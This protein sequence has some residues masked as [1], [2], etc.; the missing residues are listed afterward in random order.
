MRA[1][2]VSDESSASLRR[3]IARRGHEVVVSRSAEAI[4]AIDETIDVVVLSIGDAAG[5]RLSARIKTRFQVPFLPVLALR[6]RRTRTAHEPR[7]PDATLP[8]A[9]PPRDI[10]DRMEELVR[11]R[12]AER[13]LVRLNA[14]L[15]ELA[16]ENGRLYDRARRDAEATASLLREL[17]HRVRNNLASIQAL[18]VLERHRQ[19]S[20]PLS[21]AIDVAIA[22]LRSMAAL[23]DIAHTGAGVVRLRSLVTAITQSALEVFGAASELT[24][25]IAGDADATTAQGGAAAIVVNELVTNVVKHARATRLTVTIDGGP[26]TTAIVVADDGVGMPESAL[27][28]SG[29]AIAR[30]VARNELRGSIASDSTP[31]GARFILAFP[32]AQR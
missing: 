18:L 23:Q 6:R 11:V 4:A 24:V 15:V 8:L 1:L 28:G 22:R 29:L 10:V 3:A 25:D 21:E 32:N 13:E 9:A 20:R 31:G 27:P 5:T 30:A 7:A 19:P 14:S 2:L 26:V 16:A 17:Q 12:R